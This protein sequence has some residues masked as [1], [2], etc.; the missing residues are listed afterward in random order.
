MNAKTSK[1]KLDR[2]KIQREKLAE[3]AKKLKAQIQK[4]ESLDKAKERKRDL[5][6]KVLVGSFVLEESKKN[7]TEE[8]LKQKMAKFLKRAVDR[9]LFGLAPLKKG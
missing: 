8:E 2:L 3:Q 9:A 7:G 5:Q 4:V 6:K 1:T